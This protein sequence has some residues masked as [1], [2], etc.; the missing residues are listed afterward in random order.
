MLT[1]I[2]IDNYRCFVNFEFRPQPKQ[3][4]LGVNGTGKSVFLE[5]L[6]QLRDFVIVK[7]G[8]RA[9]ELFGPETLTRWETRPRQS[10]ELEVTG[11]GGTYSY[12][13]WIEVQDRQP[14]AR[15]IKEA[16]D[17]DAKPLALFQEDQ[18]QLFDDDH[19]QTAN[20]PFDPVRS[21]LAM[22]GPRKA[23]SKLTWFKEW[24]ERLYC[25]RINPSEMGTEAKGQEQDEILEDNLSNFAAWYG[26]IIQEQTHLI[27]DL[28]GSLREVL[29]GFDTLDLPRSGRTARVLVAAFFRP[30]G[31]DESAPRKQ[32]LPFDFNEL[33]DG[34]KALIVLYTL[35]HCAVGPDTTICIDEPDNYL[36]LAEI[37]PWL[38]ALSDRIDDEGGQ[39][40]LISHHPELINLLAPQ[41]GV[42]F[43]RTGGGPVRVEPYRPD[44]LG[45]LSP[46]EQI[47]RG[48]ERD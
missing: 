15:V 38:F 30:S 28:Q 8:Y 2:Y 1:R 35:L 26:H 21:A 19:I 12:T 47:A 34:Q 45:I 18:V 24:F 36:A 7:P 3:L 29:D 46:S 20:Y 10:F 17:F 48:W 31:N 13:L 27:P 6:G 41:H 44:A 23:N 16:L 4:I 37:Q 43:S 25:L 9:G 5:V 39:A 22:I 42:L 33:S 14:R 40:I 11:N 32:S